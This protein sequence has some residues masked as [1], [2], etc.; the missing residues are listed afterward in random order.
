MVLIWYNIQI[1]SRDQIDPPSWKPIGVDSWQPYNYPL[2]LEK[3]Q[4]QIDRLDSL[5]KD[6]CKSLANVALMSSLVR[7]TID[8][9]SGN[10]DIDNIEL[11]EKLMRGDCSPDEAIRALAISNTLKSLEVARSTHVGDWNTFPLIHQPIRS[12]IEEMPDTEKS[13]DDSYYKI[14]TIGHAIEPGQPSKG[15][16]IDRKRIVYRHMGGKIVTKVV[17]SVL[18]DT[19]DKDGLPR[20]FRKL[21]H[22]AAQGR[23]DIDQEIFPSLGEHLED[24]VRTGENHDMT[25]LIPLSTIYYSYKV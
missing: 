22:E 8:N 6:H 2:A 15:V 24:A 20:E 18:V 25:G 14:R 7:Q 1:M 19:T 9:V 10:L 17:S 5:G 3:T 23:P 16:S 12:A 21:L 13:K 4:A 11:R